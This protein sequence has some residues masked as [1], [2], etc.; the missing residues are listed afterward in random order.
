MLAIRHARPDHLCNPKPRP[1]YDLHTIPMADVHP[2]S[3]PRSCAVHDRGRHRDR[4]GL[5]S[6]LSAARADARREYEIGRGAQSTLNPKRKP[7]AERARAP[8]KSC[9]RHLPRNQAASHPENYVVGKPLTSSTTSLPPTSAE[10]DQARSFS[11]FSM[12]TCAVFWCCHIRTPL[13]DPS[14]SGHVAACIQ[15]RCARPGLHCGRWRHCWDRR[16]AGKG[17]DILTH[18]YGGWHILLNT[19]DTHLGSYE[20]VCSA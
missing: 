17:L 15:M 3:S 5:G 4:L 12:I 9:F 2:K 13:Q 6:A 1:S 7:A 20:S 19:L 18:P 16:C 11:A 14:F 10:T 8:P